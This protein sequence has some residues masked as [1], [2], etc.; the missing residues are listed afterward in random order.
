MNRVTGPYWWAYWLMIF[1]TAVL[2][3][4]FWFKRV[5]H[6]AW[7]MP[8]YFIPYYI[9]QYV[10]TLTSLHRD[11]LPTTWSIL[12]PFYLDWLSLSLYAIALTGMYYL[13]DWRRNKKGLQQQPS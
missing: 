1:N 11:Y 12:N 7:A 2:P 3:N 13:I 9:E 8:I 6:A 5:R 10:I 4:L